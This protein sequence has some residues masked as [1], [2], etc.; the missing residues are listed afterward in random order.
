MRKKSSTYPA[1]LVTWKECEP[2]RADKFSGRDTDD[3]IPSRPTCGNI[4]Y[5]QT[6]VGAIGSTDAAAKLNRD[7]YAVAVDYK[8]LSH[9]VSKFTAETAR[10][11]PYK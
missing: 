2:D 3:P 9:F 5:L 11:I 10:G 7:N 4:F 6:V 1:A 8:Y